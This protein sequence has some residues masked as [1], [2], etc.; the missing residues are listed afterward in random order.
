MPNEMQ[1]LAGIAKRRSDLIKT[2]NI[3]PKLEDQFVFDPSS[4]GQY[5]GGTHSG[6]PP[7]FVQQSHYI[8]EQIING[9]IVPLMIDNNPYVKYFETNYPI[10]NLHIH[11]KKTKDFIQK[12]IKID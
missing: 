6:L 5:F 1:F 12:S 9:N 7:G 3:I 10:V 2:L 11:S 8:G 4:Y